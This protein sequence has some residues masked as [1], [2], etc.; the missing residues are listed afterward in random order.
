[1]AILGSSGI[2]VGD[3]TLGGRNF[4]SGNG[5]DGIQIF[6]GTADSV[7]GD[8]IGGDRSGLADL[9]NTGDG[10]FDFA[11]V[12]NSIG[13]PLPGQGDT[14]FGNGGSGVDLF[15]T[16]LDLVQGSTIGLNFSGSLLSSVPNRDGT[17]HQLGNVQDGVLV[18]GGELATIGGTAAGARNVISGNLKNGITIVDDSFQDSIQG[19]LVGLDPLG[20]VA[21]GNRLNG[22]YVA[23]PDNVIGG[24]Y[25]DASGIEQPAGNVV[26]GNLNSGVVL[27]TES[28]TGNLVAGNL[29]G[30]DATGADNPM[31]M[32]PAFGADGQSIGNRQDG[33]FVNDDA[34]LN[35]IGGTTPGTRNLISGNGSNGVQV[36]GVGI[37]PGLA[38]PLPPGNT[39]LGNSIGTDLTGLA[40]DGNAADGVFLYNARDNVVGMPGAGN[41]ITGNLGSGVAIQ[42]GAAT[43]N[44]VLSNTIGMARPGP[45]VPGNRGDGV[46]VVEAAL[47]RVGGSGPD[48]GNTITG[49]G[50]TGVSVSS[51]SNFTAV[52]GNVIVDNMGDG[53]SI[54]SNSDGSGV[55]GNRI[56]VDAFGQ[57]MGNKLDGVR[58]SSAGTRVVSDVIDASGGA[59]VEVAGDSPMSSIQGNAIGVAPDGKTAQGNA[60]GVLIDGISNVTVGGLGPVDGNTI[61]GNKVGVEVTAP[62]D[63]STRLD[64]LIVGNIIGLDVT[65]EAAAGN[66]FGVFLDDVVGVSVGGAAAG[67]RNIISGNADVGV[68]VFRVTSGRL[69]DTIEG[70][71]I[72]LDRDGLVVPAGATVQPIGVFLNSASDNVVSGNVISG[73][74]A[75]TAGSTGFGVLIFGQSIG[76]PLDN[77]VEGN[78]IGLDIDKRPIAAQRAGASRSR[79]SGWP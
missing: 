40:E 8:V 7:Q 13:G 65:G 43:N 54:A 20:L 47:N 60:V 68:Q 71:T 70:N 27:S 67:A 31:V 57:P 77:L 45:G 11:G 66:G 59:G 35:T 39:I 17:P 78:T 56:G 42:G 75:T 29:I 74:E 19:N 2:R 76:Q 4:I 72:G 48:E 69:G 9:G 28:A 1:M 15:G 58:V 10:I 12:G 46:T 51:G 52:V 55:V 6:A 21:R 33:V 34:I 23:S 16:Q 32:D 73:N 18:N 53:V 64:D 25:V 30:T 5:R 41:T 26:S 24:T 36:L 3:G 22:I 44:A 50:G 61:S 37:N 79:S 38:G 63:P 62:G 49:N 14:I